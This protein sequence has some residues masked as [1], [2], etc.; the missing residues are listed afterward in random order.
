MK[1]NRNWNWNWNWNPSSSSIRESFKLY[2][3]SPFVSKT[4]FERKSI[5]EIT[6]KEIVKHIETLSLK[7]RE[8]LGL[9][10]TI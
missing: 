7:Q 3:L 5:Q 8:Q 6:P 9:Y 1:R 10:K 2:I 4:E